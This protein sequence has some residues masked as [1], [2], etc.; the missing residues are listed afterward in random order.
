MA[1]HRGT[2][3]EASDV[4][5]GAFLVLDARP[6]ADYHAGHLAGAIHVPV[7]DWDSAIKSDTGSIRNVK[8][9]NDAIGELGIDGSKPVAIYDDGKATDAARVWFIL[10]YFGVHAAV[11]NG[12]WPA[13]LAVSRQ[14]VQAGANQAPRATFS[15]KPGTGVVGF[16][17]RDDV[18]GELGSAQ[19]FDARTQA[20]YEGR[21]LRTNPR[22]GHL[23]GAM[24]VDHNKLLGADGKLLGV[25]ELKQL[26]DRA[27]FAADKPIITHCQGG[28]RA[29]LAAL[30]ATR[31]GYTD[32]HNY[33]LGFGE[34]AQDDSCPVA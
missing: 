6:V 21:D 7:A 15:G 14:Q 23:P 8:Y 31:A 26:F 11:V 5:G 1:D 22:G 34:W 27:G 29:A 20:E 24:T 28:G 33:Y 13:L 4:R 2:I 10:Q 32:V 9:W 3:V 18:R 17:D 19:V 16:K 25:L 30:A 12:N